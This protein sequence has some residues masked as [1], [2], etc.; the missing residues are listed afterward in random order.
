V[1]VYLAE[2]KVRCVGTDGPT[3]GGVDPRQALMVYWA[4]AGRGVYPVEYLTNVGKLPQR[5][6]FFLFAPIKI[7]GSRGGYGRALA[8]Y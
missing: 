4:A 8:L 6:A 1:I 5:G 7:E 2:K 3:L